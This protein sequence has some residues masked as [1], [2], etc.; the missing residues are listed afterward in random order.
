MVSSQGLTSKMMLDLAIGPG[1]FDF[2]AAYSLRRSATFSCSLTTSKAQNTKKTTTFSSSSESDPKRSMS[3]SSSAAAAA[4]EA[5]F[6]YQRATLANFL[7]S[8]AAL[9]ESKSAASSP[10]RTKPVA[11]ACVASA[12][13]KALRPASFL[14]S[15][16]MLVLEA[17]VA[18][19]EWLQRSC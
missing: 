10:D 5:T 3:S 18:T 7:A 14:R 15:K 4:E 1:F 11:N 16:D 13:L 12:S 2:L 8:G 19:K 9:S 17:A 6:L